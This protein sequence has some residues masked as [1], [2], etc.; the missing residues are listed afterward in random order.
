MCTVGLLG[1]RIRMENPQA[2]E[3][4]RGAD[5]QE[6]SQENKKAGYQE[7]EEPGK[8]GGSMDQKPGELHHPHADP[9]NAYGSRRHSAIRS[10]GR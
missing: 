5:L 7:D 6:Q 10:R 9:C 4:R 2:E 3:V 1:P 8:K